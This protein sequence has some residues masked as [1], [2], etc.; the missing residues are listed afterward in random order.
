M[1]IYVDGEKVNDHFYTGQTVPISLGYLN[2]PEKLTVVI[3]ALYEDTKVFIEDWPEMEA[4]K[5]CR[6]DEISIR[7]EVR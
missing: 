2:H 5:A 3:T 4:G 1:D 7:E 6:I